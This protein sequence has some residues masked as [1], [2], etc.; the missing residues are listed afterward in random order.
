VPASGVAG[1]EGRAERDAGETTCEDGRRVLVRSVSRWE[2]GEGKKT[3]LVR[4]SKSVPTRISTAQVVS[5]LLRSASRARALSAALASAS[6]FILIQSHA[7]VR[8]CARKGR[9]VV[10]WLVVA[11]ARYGTARGAGREA[12]C[13]LDAGAAERMVLSQDLALTTALQVVL[14]RRRG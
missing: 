11:R 7:H 5:V 9:L 14:T 8:E 10:Q 4:I 1:R 2:I 6:R 13:E 12:R 3:H